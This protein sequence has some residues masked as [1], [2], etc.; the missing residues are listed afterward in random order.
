L[1]ISNKATQFQAM[2]TIS[3][4]ELRSGNRRTL[5]KAITLIESTREG[6]HEPAQHLLAD[7]MP[8]TGNAFRIG[9]SGVP[10]VG[11][12]TFIESLGMLLLSLGHR[13]AVLA[14]DPSSPFSGGS[15]LGD[16]TRMEKLAA[17]PDA[18]IRP[19]PT[20]GSLGGVAL[21]T[22]ESMLLC[23]AAGYNVILV[24]TVGVGQSEYEVASMTDLFLL[25][26]LPGAGDALQGIKRGILELADLLVVNKAEG[27]N[28]DRAESA[29]REILQGIHYLQPRDDEKPTE[30]LLCSALTNEGVH[31]VW[32]QV[33]GILQR[34]QS[35]G[36]LDS[37]RRKQ[38]LNWVR[39]M[40]EQ[41]VLHRFW[42]DGNVQADYMKMI[43]ELKAGRITPAQAVASVLQD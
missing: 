33:E 2:H 19:S 22:R 31:D 28:R 16:K 7:I 6:D 32:T 17:S 42:N 23:E 36:R 34:M 5:S 13:V 39:K 20:A 12:S 40:I 10:G 11:K 27:E 37:N 24:E 3:L 43:S 18:F 14:V 8:H 9:I 30:V 21:R 26:M 38:L 15:I 29:R 25:L 35:S 41:Q 1:L 4:D